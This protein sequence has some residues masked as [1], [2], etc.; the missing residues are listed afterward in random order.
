MC[1]HAHLI[2]VVRPFVSAQV[3]FSAAASKGVLSSVL[4]MFGALLSIASSG[5]SLYWQKR[6]RVS[7]QPQ[8]IELAVVVSAHDDDAQLQGVELVGVP[9]QQQP[10]VAEVPSRSSAGNDAQPQSIELVG[11]PLQQQQPVVAEVPPRS[12]AGNDAQPQGVELVGVPLQ[13]Q[14][15]VV[16]EEKATVAQP[17]IANPDHYSEQGLQFRSVGTGE[18]DAAAVDVRGHGAAASA[19]NVDDI[20]DVHLFDPATNVHTQIPSVV[21]RR[22]VAAGAGA[23][24]ELEFSEETVIPA[25]CK[26]VV[27][28]RKGSLD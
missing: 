11:V 26:L 9:L 21:C 24:I 25:R 16:A 4:L 18:G 2:D 20:M 6:D 1:L 8:G 12:S 10:V 27:L 17:Q 15:P 13:Q 19:S 3:F 14:Q 23:L 5:L 22:G 28:P 7:V